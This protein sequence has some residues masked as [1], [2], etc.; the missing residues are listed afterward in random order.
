MPNEVLSISGTAECPCAQKKLMQDLWFN[1]HMFTI[2]CATRG[3]LTLETLV[4]SQERCAD[5]YK[6]ISLSNERSAPVTQNDIGNVAMSPSAMTATQKWHVAA[7]NTSAK[8]HAFKVSPQARPYRL[9][10]ERGERFNHIERTHLHPENSKINDKSLY[11]SGT[12]IL[13]PFDPNNAEQSTAKIWSRSRTKRRNLGNER[14]RMVSL[15]FYRSPWNVHWLSH[16]NMWGNLRSKST[17]FSMVFLSQRL[18]MQCTFHRPCDHR[19]QPSHLLALEMR[20]RCS[21]NWECYR[22]GDVGCSFPS[23]VADSCLNRTFAG[24]KT[25]I[26]A[27]T[28][29]TFLSIQFILLAKFHG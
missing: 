23:L 22:H 12:H 25:R 10:R 2:P 11:A 19:N 26:F 27:W 7:V 17:G 1:K 14:W 8:W 6:R 20:V 24:A 15:S 16:P 21:W 13:L 5:R 28:D 9:H 18:T 3:L 29:L 4:Y